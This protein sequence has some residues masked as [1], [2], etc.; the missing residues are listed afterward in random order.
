MPF[1]LADL[2][3]EILD[4][5]LVGNIAGDSELTLSRVLVVLDAE[6]AIIPTY[7]CA[8]PPNSLP[9]SLSSATFFS[10]GSL[11]KATMYTLAPFLTSPCYKSQLLKKSSGRHLKIA[12][13]NQHTK[14][15]LLSQS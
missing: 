12:I 2:S 8:E 7:P 10:M 4:S 1:L 14:I 11:G 9:S 3:G 15:H 5:L 6:L 13:L